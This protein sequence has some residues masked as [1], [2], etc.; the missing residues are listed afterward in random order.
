M[1]LCGTL[2]IT[3][4]LRIRRSMIFPTTRTVAGMSFGIHATRVALDAFDL[5]SLDDFAVHAMS[6]GAH[7][8]LW[9]SGPSSAARKSAVTAIDHSR[10]H[11]NSPINVGHVTPAVPASQG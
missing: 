11:S 2:Q 3:V 8:L 4:L 10:E 7:L 1:M 6:R 9:A 5:G